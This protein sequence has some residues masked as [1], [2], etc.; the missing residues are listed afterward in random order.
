MTL[1]PF[2]SGRLCP[3]QK[4]KY[5][6]CISLETNKMYW[7]PNV[8]DEERI[9]MK[10]LTSIKKFLLALKNCNL[11]TKRLRFEMKKYEF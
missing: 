4:T 1:V 8:L 5:K 11:T 10:F 3:E 9:E 6:L 2:V 7:E